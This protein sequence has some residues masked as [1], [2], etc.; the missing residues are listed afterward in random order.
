MLF[1][2]T[3]FQP[4]IF[5]G[6]LFI[7]FLLLSMA[8]NSQ[9]LA[10]W[11]VTLILV[12]LIICSQYSVHVFASNEYLVNI[13]QSKGKICLT[14]LLSC[15]NLS[16]QNEAYASIEFQNIQLYLP[17]FALLVTF[18]LSYFILTSENYQSLLQHYIDKEVKLQIQNKMQ[19]RKQNTLN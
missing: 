18:V 12:S 13:K 4:N 11:R 1:F 5:N 9:T 17:Y 15:D 6:I 7:M 3:A 8:N 10:Y 2:V 14:G 19:L 16:E